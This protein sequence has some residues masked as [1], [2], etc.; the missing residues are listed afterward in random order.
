MMMQSVNRSDVEVVYVNITNSDGQTLTAHHPVFKFLAN[1]NTASVSTNEGGRA[2]NTNAVASTPGSFIGLADQ[3][4][5]DGQVGRVQV[6]GYH[7]SALVFRIVGSVTTIPG[8]AMGPGD[9]ANTNGIAS[10]GFIQGV[11]GPVV[12]LDTVTA[13]MHSLGTSGAVFCNHVYLRAM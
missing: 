2:T 4:I 6:F 5:A 11:Y 7:A 13:T 1:R 9:C 10:N 8:H 12:A 3:D